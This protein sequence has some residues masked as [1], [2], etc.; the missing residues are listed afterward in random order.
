[1][2]YFR[3]MQIGEKNCSVIGAVSGIL[4]HSDTHLYLN[5]LN[6]KTEIK[7]LLFIQRK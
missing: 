7:N 2:D 1:M 4:R 3:K 6:L 5:K